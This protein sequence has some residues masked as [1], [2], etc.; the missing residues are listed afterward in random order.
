MAFLSV[1]AMEYSENPEFSM[2]RFFLEKRYAYESKFIR[3]LIRKA[4]SLRLRYNETTMGLSSM[5][6]IYCAL[7]DGMETIIHRTEAQLPLPRKDEALAFS[8]STA[9]RFSGTSIRKIL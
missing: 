9:R 4:E 8:Q 3:D 2:E 1:L 5:S 7:H 6:A